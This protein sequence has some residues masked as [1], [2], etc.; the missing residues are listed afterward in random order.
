MSTGG[1]GRERRLRPPRLSVGLAERL[2]GR[3]LGGEFGPGERLPGNRELAAAYSVSVGSV[4]EA[5]QRLASEGLVEVRPGSGTYVSRDLRGSPW[6]PGGEQPLLDREQVEELIEAREVLEPRLAEL[7]AR[8]AS[9]EQV[10]GLWRALE[11]MQESVS[12]PSAFAE[13]DV[14]FHMAVAEASGNRFLTRATADIRSL[15][16]RDMELSAEVGI[17]RA[18]TLQF[19]VDSHRR[20]VAAIAAGDP[21]K[22]G[23]IV[24]GILRRNR[25]FVIGLY[26]GGVSAEGSG[27]F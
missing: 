11:R 12:D 8:R 10:E 16:R 7:A 15:L 25:G 2:R 9:A 1:S 4:R 5:L 13:A 19:S 27:E 21:E 18:G 6:L 26:S 20:L 17:R 24:S 23:R 14:G 3:I 22:A